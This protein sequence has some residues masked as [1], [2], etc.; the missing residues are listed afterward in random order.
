MSNTA[1]WRLDLYAQHCRLQVPPGAVI[2]SVGEPPNAHIP[3]IWFA[4]DPSDPRRV[5]RKFILVRTGIPSLYLE[6]LSLVG[7][8][9]FP[10]APGQPLV[11]C[12]V[13]EVPQEGA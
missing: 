5:T 13:F 11:E 3:S 10:T 6:R 2:L 8:T 1:I 4:V 12:H 7:R 9:I